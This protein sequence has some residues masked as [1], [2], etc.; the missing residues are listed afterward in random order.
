MND[1]LQKAG[2][3]GGIAAAIVGLLTLV[4]ARF[5]AF[6][7]DET[8]LSGAEERITSTVERAVERAVDRIEAQMK[9]MRDRNE[10]QMEELRG[11]VVDHLDGHPADD[12]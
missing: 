2:A 1:R 8:E 11:Y 3:V 12:Q 5:G 10:A 6:F 4:L 7:V 9:E